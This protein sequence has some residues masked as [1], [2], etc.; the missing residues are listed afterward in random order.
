MD[1][2]HNASILWGR[3]GA[4]PAGAAIPHAGDD[5]GATFRALQAFGA[6]VQVQL[7]FVAHPAKPPTRPALPSPVHTRIMT[8]T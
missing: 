5:S 4:P 1:V 2:V 7:F 8:K 6:A 3:C